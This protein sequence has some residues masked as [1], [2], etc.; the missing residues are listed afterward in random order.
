MR[1]AAV[2]TALLVIGSAARGADM[3]TLS[4]MPENRTL[5][6]RQLSLAALQDATKPTLAYASDG[7]EEFIWTATA[8]DGK[9]YFSHAT[10]YC[11]QNKHTPVSKS[12]WVIFNPGKAVYDS[13][14][15]RL[16][17]PLDAKGDPNK[18]A[19]ATQGQAALSA[20]IAS[21]HPKYGTLYQLSLDD[22][23]DFG[24]LHR[25]KRIFVLHD[26]EHG[27]RY[28]GT[29]AGEL[30][31]GGDAID[32][33]ESRHVITYVTWTGV[34]EAPVRIDCSVTGALQ[35]DEPRLSI[36]G[37]YT[38]SGALPVKMR[39]AHYALTIRN[40]HTLSGLTPILAHWQ[41]GNGGPE[42]TPAQMQRT[43]LALNPRLKADRL[44]LGTNLTIPDIY[45]APPHH[46]LAPAASASR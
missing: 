30:S 21:A 41:T 44:R 6:A 35:F 33:S 37:H 16:T 32:Y 9:R 38:L 10:V 40:G 18:P 8:A 27:W 2:L 15:S 3:A 25:E 7:H 11:F 1:C 17:T 5:Y 29:L 28:V 31:V 39:H 4:A 20:V 46:P 23:R 14:D 24:D 42:T 45:D 12:Q 34:P 36:A 13:I 19:L 43:I 26:T 22:A